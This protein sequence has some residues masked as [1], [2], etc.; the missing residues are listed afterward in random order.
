MIG[1]FFSELRGVT[2][3]ID[4]VETRLRDREALDVD[5]P[6]HHA[7]QQA[8]L[9]NFRN[10]V[11]ETKARMKTL[12]PTVVNLQNFSRINVVGSQLV[13]LQRQRVEAFKTHLV[14]Y[15][16]EEPPP[17]KVYKSDDGRDGRDDPHEE[18]SSPPV[19]AAIRRP[20]VAQHP[21]RVSPIAT[22]SSPVEE[23]M[24]VGIEPEHVPPPVPLPQPRSLPVASEP[25]CQNGLLEFPISPRCPILQSTAAGAV[26][27]PSASSVSC[28]VGVAVEESHPPPEVDEGDEDSIL[29]MELPPTPVCP[30]ITWQS[31]PDTGAPGGV[32]TASFPPRTPASTMPFAH[33]PTPPVLLSAAK[34]TLDVTK[35]DFSGLEDGEVFHTGLTPKTP[36]LHSVFASLPPP[37]STTTMSRSGYPD[38]P[39]EGRATPSS[40]DSRLPFEALK[41]ELNFHGNGESAATSE[42]ASGVKP[43]LAE[44][45]KPVSFI[46]FEQK[47]Q[48]VDGVT[49]DVLNNAIKSLNAVFRKKEE[50]KEALVLSQTQVDTL[51]NEDNDL[52][53]GTKIILM[54]LKFKRI[55]CRS[56]H[57]QSYVSPFSEADDS[58]LDATNIDE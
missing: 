9:R 12:Q 7:L 51:F 57:G 1:E 16:Y 38:T 32:G 37:P 15:G 35:I 30:T 53:L 21:P 10:D 18:K 40:P 4:G 17:A 48:K 44:Y 23:D 8:A 27:A 41:R 55:D 24:E 58:I 13:S 3:L 49:R 6:Q 22:L 11:I 36:E 2:S 33:T 31:E 54:L 39:F 25:R 19:T 45:M 26:T 46:E 52:R 5:G 50:A 14:R 29:A 47:P 42:A 34:K 28:H 56:A 20:V 43:L